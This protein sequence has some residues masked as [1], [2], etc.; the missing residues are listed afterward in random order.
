[1]IRLLRTRFPRG[2][3]AWS[4]ALPAVVACGGEGNVPPREPNPSDVGSSSSLAEDNSGDVPHAGGSVASGGGAASVGGALHDVGGA[5]ISKGGGAQAGGSGGAANI[6]GG[7]R[8]GTGGMA[9][10]GG[11]AGASAGAAHT[12]EGGTSG[13]GTGG[14]SAGAAGAAGHAGGMSY[15]TNFGLTEFPISEAGVWQHAGLDW[16]QVRTAGGYAF[17]TQAGASSTGGYDDSYAYLSGFPANHSASAVI[18]KESGIASCCHEVELLLRWTDAE[19]D[20]HGYECNLAY[21][22]AYAQIVRWNGAVGSFT[23]VG[24]AGSVPGGV[25]DGDTLSCSIVGD[26]ISLSVNGVERAKGTDTTFKTGNPGIGF[27][28]RNAS[29]AQSDYGFTSFTAQAL[30]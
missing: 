21:D 13:A 14:A 26:S 20:A 18:H 9:G 22:G 1:V 2:T 19:H 29:I 5:A 27:F 8:G 16:T 7:S 3:L 17:G 11:S 24:A 23:Y 25:K 30:P 12:V 4:L 28:R 10:R 6:G 15:T